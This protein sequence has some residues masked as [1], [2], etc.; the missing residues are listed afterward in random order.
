M[1]LKSRIISVLTAAVTLLS[2]SAFT[3]SASAA[4]AYPE[5][6]TRAY[7]K[8]ELMRAMGFVGTDDDLASTLTRGEFAAWLCKIA[9]KSEDEPAY[10]AE[11]SDVNGDTAYSREIS[12]AAAEGYMSGSGGKFNPT[13]AVSRNE[14]A[15][16]LVRLAGYDAYARQK[17][18]YPAGY[19][20]QASSLGIL[21]GAGTEANRYNLLMMCYN[22]LCGKMLVPDGIRDGNV[23]YSDD[24]KVIEHCHDIYEVRG[25][26]NANRFTRLQSD[27]IVPSP[28]SV[29]IDGVLYDTDADY[30]G[31]I[32]MSVR[33]F[34]RIDSD[35]DD[36]TIVSLYA[37]D[38]DN[39]VLELE[40][41]E[42][43]GDSLTKNYA[44]SYRKNNSRKSVQ[45]VKGFDFVW[46]NRID[47]ARDNA[48]IFK[49]DKIRLID[50]NNDGKYETVIAEKCETMKF[51]SVDLHTETVYCDRGTLKKSSADGAYMGFALCDGESRTEVYPEQLEA[52]MV[53]SVYRSKDGLYVQGYA[54][55]TVLSGTVGG[56]DDED[57]VKIGDSWYELADSVDKSE[58]VMG[59]EVD[60][61]L[62]MLG[63]IAYIDTAGGSFDYKY[64]YLFSVRSITEDETT[65]A[66]LITKT[67]ELKLN[68]EDSF[69]LDGEKADAEAALAL[70]RQLIR[71]KINRKGNIRSIDTAKFSTYNKNDDS[72]ELYKHAQMKLYPLSGI[73]DTKFKLTGSTFT[74]VVPS[75]ASEQD[76]IEL[77]DTVF[78]FNDEPQNY[79]FACFDIDEKD[80]S[81]GAC[82][83][84]DA[85]SRKGQVATDG[86]TDIGIVKKIRRECVDGDIVDRVT[87]FTK[88]GET[89]Y[90]AAESL[91]QEDLKRL[92]FGDVVRYVINTKGEV[93]TIYKE[94]DVNRDEVLD[95]V[96]AEKTSGYYDFN[97][98][99]VLRKENDYLVL[100]SNSDNA[101]YSVNTFENR[102]IIYT[103]KMQNC[104]LVDMTE[105]TVEMCDLSNV[106]QYIADGS[107]S[108]VYARTYKYYNLINLIVYK[109]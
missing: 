102:R 9:G 88:T 74:L 77:Y 56:I 4:P 24:E 16:A 8:M 21:S 15:A 78:D 83:Y 94:C 49:A 93:S 84:Y 96:L 64:A 40:D 37:D 72:L 81:V 2:G 3:V 66:K 54:T 1:R 11:F 71:Y 26:M 34:C 65:L 50:S 52:G 35:T 28:Y 98:G 33:G 76:D 70:S 85:K 105:G 55:E 97:F 39:K 104:W 63:R 45:L 101:D 100:L 57:G 20:V 14:T 91:M 46:N 18:G 62:D 59:T 106:A 42:L 99:R 32:G 19:L 23:T 87:L 44:L 13:D 108:Y 7:G 109:Y 67:G 107:P 73:I 58:F 41:D 89:A 75:I 47:L 5:Y 17:G 92:S 12:I 22:T 25:V 6:G 82:I 38:A 53:L 27:D 43:E 90:T 36:K 31:L 79:D 103:S 95:T 10:G 80:M 48:D 60:L 68:I 86:G 61:L 29:E 30:N 51:L 69:L